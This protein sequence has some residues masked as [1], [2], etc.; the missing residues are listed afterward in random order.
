MLGEGKVTWGAK[1]WIMSNKITFFGTSPSLMLKGN[2][3][4]VLSQLPLPF[5]EA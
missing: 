5:N 2:V 1:F 3:S 4:E